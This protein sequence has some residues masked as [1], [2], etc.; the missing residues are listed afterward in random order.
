MPVPLDSEDRISCRARHA[1]LLNSSWSL[2]MM[3]IYRLITRSDLR[4]T[5]RAVISS[6]AHG[7]NPSSFMPLISDRE[8]VRLNRKR[9]HTAGVGSHMEEGGRRR[10]VGQEAR[11]SSPAQTLVA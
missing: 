1:T 2:G 6:I 9:R 11:P 4:A 10:G 7:R 3:L 8:R 5:A